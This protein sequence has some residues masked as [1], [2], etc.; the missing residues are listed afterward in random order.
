[1]DI[2]ALQVCLK[3]GQGYSMAYDAAIR[4]KSTEDVMTFLLKRL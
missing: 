1:M 2:N 3:E 4:A